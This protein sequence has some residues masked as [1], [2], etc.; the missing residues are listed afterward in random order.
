MLQVNKKIIEKILFNVYRLHSMKIKCWTF[1]T[2]KLFFQ[3][4]FFIFIKKKQFKQYSQTRNHPISHKWKPLQNITTLPIIHK[5]RGAIYKWRGRVKMDILSKWSP[6]SL[7]S[8]HFRH[9]RKLKGSERQKGTKIWKWN[10]EK[11][12]EKGRGR[13][14]LKRRYEF[15][16][17]LMG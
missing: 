14:A 12:R 16:K 15:I 4:N 13:L 3:G 11:G 1:K 9:N 6:P 7:K 8:T 2:W 10:R 5:Y 17:V